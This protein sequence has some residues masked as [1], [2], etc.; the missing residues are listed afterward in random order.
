MQRR[1]SRENL[2]DINALPR[3]V[4]F[5]SH[6]NTTA[7]DSPKLREQMSVAHQLARNLLRENKIGDAATITAMEPSVAPDGTHM[8]SAIVH[9]GTGAQ[10]VVWMHNGKVRKIVGA[11]GSVI[12]DSGVGGGHGR[13]R[14]S[15]GGTSGGAASSSYSENG[16]Y[17]NAEQGVSENSAGSVTEGDNVNNNA[18]AVPDHSAGSTGEGGDGADSSSFLGSSTSAWNSAASTTNL[19]DA[20]VQQQLTTTLEN[21]AK[22]ELLP[23]GQYALDDKSPGSSGFPF[24]DAK[25]KKFFLNPDGSPPANPRTGKHFLDHTTHKPF[26]DPATG[27]YF[28]ESDGNPPVDPKTG[29]RFFDPRTE[30]P[31]VDGRTGTFFLEPDGTPPVD[32]ETGRFFLDPKTKKPFLN[33]TT[34]TYFFNRDGTPP[35]DPATK[36]YFVDFRTGLPFLDGSPVPGASTKEREGSGNDRPRPFGGPAANIRVDYFSKFP[37]LEVSGVRGPGLTYL[38]GGWWPAVLL[39]NSKKPVYIRDEESVNGFRSSMRYVVSNE[40]VRSNSTAVGGTAKA[41]TESST[42]PSE[43]GRGGRWVIEAQGTER[44]AAT[45]EGDLPPEDGWH[46]VGVRNMEEGVSGSG[47]GSALRTTGMR[48]AR[49]R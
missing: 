16:Y 8:Q 11:D 40:G 38:N 35:I 18:A 9:L 45:G 4:R 20:S 27:S 19:A 22:P 34:G 6:L 33:P 21:G 1:A 13:P 10:A 30:L 26:V 3:Q 43:M 42:T 29:R 23:N 28:L 39:R 14:G 46:A 17:G 36:R 12:V 7:G 47:S 5:G 49:R 48:V 37:S 41:G 44:F 2:F 25:T 32:P 31:F 15:S 24:V